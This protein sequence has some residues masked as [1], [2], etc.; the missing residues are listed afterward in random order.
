MNN[1]LLVESTERILKIKQMIH[2][3]Y[4]MKDLDSVTLFLSIQIKHLS[5]DQIKLFQ[6]YY[7]EKLLECFNIIKCNKIHLSMKQDLQNC[8]ENNEIFSDDEFA[9]Y[10]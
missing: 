6:T 1:I 3:L 7:I 4:K 10:Q 2:S 5:D 9:D 8:N